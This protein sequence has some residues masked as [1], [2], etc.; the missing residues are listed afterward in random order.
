MTL[1]ST[2]AQVPGN[3]RVHPRFA[4]DPMLAVDGRRPIALITGGSRGIG[5]ATVLALAEAGADTAFTW[6]SRGE[7][8]HETEELARGWGG[9]VLSLQADAADFANAQQVVDEVA[10]TLGPPTILVNNAGITHDQVVW[11]MSEAAWDEVLDRNVKSC[12]NYVRAVVPHMRAAGAGRV[13]S[14]TSINALRG[15]FGQ[16]NYTA[17]KAAIIGLTKT[18]AR[19]VGRFH[20]TV[21]AIA[22]GLV[23][24]EMASK[25]VR[26]RALDETVLSCLSEPEDV[27]G[28]VLFLCT[29]A[30]RQITGDVI[31]VDGGQY[32]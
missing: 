20:V 1:P 31:K 17:S 15:K 4:L 18:V 6:H 21:N 8:A 25:E 14:L 13:I 16:S 26:R 9:R 32:L 3:H 12:F 2:A 23:Q 22:P 7:A 19:E 27:A 11:K 30:A 29:R 5:R 10:S 24:T 28:V